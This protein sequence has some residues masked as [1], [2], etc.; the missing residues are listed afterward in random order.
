VP[1]AKDLRGATSPRT[2]VRL[3]ACTAVISGQVRSVGSAAEL[4]GGRIAVLDRV[5]SALY[6]ISA[7]GQATH[8]VRPI[9]RPPL[10]EMS[11]YRGDSLLVYDRVQGR[12]TIVSPRGLGSRVSMRGDGR[13]WLLWSLKGAMSQA[14][15]VVGVDLRLWFGRPPGLY[16]DTV[17]VTGVA[18]NGEPQWRYPVIAPPLLI[19]SA[20]T[21]GR[22]DDGHLTRR[23][24]PAFSPGPSYRENFVVVGP[25]RVF[26]L[27][28]ANGT[29]VGLG[30]AGHPL[31]R[32]RV[33]SAWLA[34]E[35]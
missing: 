23:A 15:V 19:T 20:D 18:M 35:A 6:F 13:Q 34:D 31:L 32:V 8:E 27:E 12:M 22:D 2:T 26:F 4:A 14:G 25:T 11:A 1:L 29:L 9:P 21:A 10:P 16:R 7:D 30:P 17:F 28:E 5:T 33:P 3:G 24:A